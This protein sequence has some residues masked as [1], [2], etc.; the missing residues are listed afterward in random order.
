MPLSRTS[1]HRLTTLLYMRRKD[2]FAF[3]V[4][5]V[6]TSLAMALLGRYLADY[7]WTYAVSFAAV[8]ALL[9]TSTIAV[10]TKYFGRRGR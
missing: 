4:A 2:S 10:T 1:A 3:V 5:G 6:A 9:S 8:F 7:S